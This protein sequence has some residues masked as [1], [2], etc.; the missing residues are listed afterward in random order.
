MNLQPYYQK[1][2][3]WQQR[4]K[5]EGWST[6]LIDDIINQCRRLSTYEMEIDDEWLTPKAFA[7]SGLHGDCEDIAFFMIG[8]LKHL[9]Y[10]YSARVLVVAGLFS[11]HAQIKVE[12]S[13]LSW[14]WYETTRNRAYC[15]IPEEWVPIVEF[16]ETVI[17]YHAVE[18]KSITALKQ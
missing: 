18:G 10:P 7:R 11:D 12:M 5:S 2:R 3:E 6:A 14:K 15:R 1:I 4:I 17:I 9:G 8:T 13:D 16:D